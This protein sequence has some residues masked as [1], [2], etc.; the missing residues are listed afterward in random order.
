LIKTTLVT[1]GYRFNSESFWLEYL[2]H[3][4]SQVST[5][6]KS[7]DEKSSLL[8]TKVEDF[9]GIN[10]G[11]RKVNSKFKGHVTI[12]YST[13]IEGRLLDTVSL[14]MDLGA[15][16][17]S[18]SPCTPVSENGKFSA[19][20]T[21][22]YDKMVLEI[23]TN[24]KKIVDLTKGKISFSLKTPLCIWP[25]DF[26]QTIIAQKQLNTVCQFQRRSGI[27]FDTDGKIVLCN[28]MLEYPVGKYGVDF[29]DRESFLKILNSEEVNGIYNH[30][31]SYPSK[32]CMECNLF[33]RCRGGCPIMWTVF[34]A[35]EVISSAKKRKGGG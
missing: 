20:F 4:N 28:S 18:V 23:S 29:N 24:Y 15:T 1:N 6:L 21:V 34:N 26:I 27:V 9:K 11:I 33:S 8:I 7:Y 5:S 14:A 30:I 10:N 16:S 31:N 25:E 35:E 32:L 3:P 12:V 13:L 19:P 22:E 17:V 2:K